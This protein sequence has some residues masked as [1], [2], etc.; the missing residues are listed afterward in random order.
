[1]TDTHKEA[2][3]NYMKA[4]DRLFAL[5]CESMQSEPSLVG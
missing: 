5:E 3:E 2:E 1:M 4:K